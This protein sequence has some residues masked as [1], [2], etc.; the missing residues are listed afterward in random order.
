MVTE[1][2]RV[3]AAFAGI[4]AL[5]WL[6]PRETAPA[7]LPG[8]GVP[9]VTVKV[10]APSAKPSCC[11]GMRI[12]AD[13]VPAAIVILCPL[14]PPPAAPPSMSGLAPVFGALVA[15]VLACVKSATL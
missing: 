14:S 9:S 3:N 11:S 7:P 15:S 10:S 8:T 6:A 1:R 2:K 12:I 4:V 13:T 5:A